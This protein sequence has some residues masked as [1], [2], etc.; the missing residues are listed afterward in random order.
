[1]EKKI[2]NAGNNSHTGNMESFNH[3]LQRRISQTIGYSNAFY[4]ARAQQAMMDFNFQKDYKI[5]GNGVLRKNKNSEY[6]S[7]AQH[8]PNITVP[9]LSVLKA[10]LGKEFSGDK[11]Y[12]IWD[13]EK[14]LKLITDYKR[15]FDYKRFSIFSCSYYFQML[16]FIPSII[17]FITREF[18]SQKCFQY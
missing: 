7:R 13:E 17:T 5:I 16:L 10:F 3:F 12:N 15:E 9:G 6:L 4:V 1:M 14:H 8:G 2:H 11:S 18:F